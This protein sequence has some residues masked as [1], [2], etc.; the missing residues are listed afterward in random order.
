MTP[1]RI[2]R[3]PLAGRWILVKIPEELIAHAEALGAG[4]LSAG[5][6]LA[7]ANCP[8][9]EKTKIESAKTDI[10]KTELPVL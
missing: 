2:G 6:R 3:P 9:F 4:N 7:I 1:K 8:S 10:G 5:I